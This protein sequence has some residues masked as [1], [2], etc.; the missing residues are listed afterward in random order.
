MGT[1]YQQFSNKVYVYVMPESPN[2]LD[3]EAYFLQSKCKHIA[4]NDDGWKMWSPGR[5]VCHG[6]RWRLRPENI[7]DV[8]WED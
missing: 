2:L 3:P 5:K 4:Q 1:P 6:E 8:E 7:R